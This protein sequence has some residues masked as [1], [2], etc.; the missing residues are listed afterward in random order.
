MAEA[1]LRSGLTLRVIAAALALLL[2]DAIACYRIAAHFANLVY[3]RWL[4][5]STRSLAQALRTADGEVRIQLP[6][7]ALQIFQFD[8]V[9]KTD[10]R[11]DTL[12]RG[13]IAGDAALPLMRGPADGSV[14]LQTA[15]VSGHRM[16]LV[17]TTLPEPQVHDIA[18]V[19]VGETLIKRSTLMTEILLAMA[20]PQLALLITALIF[21]WLAVSH[22]LK[23]L[24]TLASAIEARG[25]DNMTP[26]SERN[27]PKE[28]RVLVS[29]INDLLA[30]LER[31]MLAQQRFVADAAHQLRTPL[32]AILLYAERAERAA[33]PDSER[34]AL[35][36]LHSA[37]A[38]AAR[39]SQQLLALARAEPDAAAE[40]ALATLD[41]VGLARGVGEEWIPRALE[42]KIDF[43][44]LAPDRPVMVAG[45]AGLL[46]ELMSNLIDNALRYGG[47]R[48]R[49]TLSVE[50]V[51]VP[52]ISVE[53]DG[54]GIPAAER[55]R[56]FERFYRLAESG[57]EGCGLGLA[58]V[59]EIAT[60]HR[61]VTRVGSGIDGRGARFTVEF[62][63]ASREPGRAAA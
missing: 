5:D 11:V 48:C 33:D 15:T 13:L 6:E 41:L 28:A 20:A 4:I 44:F 29:K 2:L 56:I 45:H 60:L 36:G 43:G 31:A 38:R 16:R 51:P 53:D 63:S 37:V 19:E 12:R 14:Q 35:R 17:A 54:P 62:P 49:V 57:T 27:L 22:G 47:P 30:R 42:R 10:F 18:T 39:L 25:H 61:A 52:A 46:G 26:V 23:P 40:R 24:T 58:I 7:V 21:A 32:A 9:D 3:D 8:A 59:K 34:Q 50:A 1:S 55:D